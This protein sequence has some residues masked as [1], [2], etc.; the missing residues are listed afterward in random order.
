M[1]FKG[2]RRRFFDAE[3]DELRAE[4]DEYE[5]SIPEIR[6]EKQEFF[7][8]YANAVQDCIDRNAK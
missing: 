7:D 3:Y 8:S 5:D 6:R 2:P 1:I 4:I